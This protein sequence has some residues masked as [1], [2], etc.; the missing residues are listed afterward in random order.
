VQAV[1]FVAQRLDGVDGAGTLRAHRYV[2][3]SGMIEG[4]ADAAADRIGKPLLRANGFNQARGEAAAQNLIHHLDREVVGGAAL[5]AQLN[6]FD[7]ALVDVILRHEVEAGLGLMKLDLRLGRHRGLLPALESLPQSTLHCGGIEIAGD[8]EDDVVGVDILLVPLQQIVAGDGGNGGVFGD[9]GVRIIGAVG[10]AN[11]FAAGDG[12]DVI[13][14][15]GDAGVHLKL[16]QSDL[17]V[18]EGG[19]AQ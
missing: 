12:V 2:G 9:A 13:I 6:H 3:D 11:G 5:D 8:A 4:S 18:A 16:G 1:E 10:E 17:V 7:R 14:A 19:V 15:A